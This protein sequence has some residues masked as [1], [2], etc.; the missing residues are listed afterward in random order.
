MATLITETKWHGNPRPILAYASTVFEEL[1]VSPY[2]ADGRTVP[3]YNSYVTPVPLADLAPVATATI[4]GPAATVEFTMDGLWKD[5]TALTVLIT[6]TG[7]LDFSEVVSWPPTA[8]GPVEAASRMA[9]LITASSG[10]MGATSSGQ[11]VSVFVTAP[12]TALTITTLT[13]SP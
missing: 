10:D 7:G 3:T 2:Y 8:L 5:P 1:V 9:A 12:S 13:V 4:A 6:S 11:L